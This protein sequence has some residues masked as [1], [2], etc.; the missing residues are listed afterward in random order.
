VPDI[1]WFRRDLRLTDHGG[2]DAAV[3]HEVVPVFVV[4]PRLWRSAGPVR[5]SRL[6]ASLRALDAGIRERGGAG[7]VV[8]RGPP[9][10]VVPDAA[11]E[12]GA[13]RV[14]HA[15][16]HTP[17]GRTRDA[18]VRVRLRQRG[19][20][21]VAADSPYL[22]PPGEVR[23]AAGGPYSVFT[24]YYRAWS[25][26]P[27]PPPF[28]GTEVQFAAAPGDGLPQL[29]RDVP[30][31]EPVARASLAAFARLRLDRYDVDRNRPDRD[32][33]SQL[34]AALHFGELHP[35]SVVAA[36]GGPSGAGAGFVRQMCW[37][38]FYADVMHRQPEAATDNIDRR[39]DR[40]PWLVGDEADRLFQAWA[41]G[42]TG[43]PFVDA[44]MRQLAQS[45]WMHNRVRM[46]VASF[47]TKD[48]LIHWNRGAAWFL[49]HLLD[50]DVANNALGWQWTAGTGTDAAPY[51]RVFNP[52]LQG[53]KFDSD[54]DYVRRFVPELAHLPGASVHEPWRHPGGYEHGYP[55]RIVDHAEA[56][57]QALGIYEQI[58]APSR[59][60][61][62]H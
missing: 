39:F 56:R 59:Q 5:R 34:G 55:E 10:E 19:I 29:E 61:E 40:M 24:P 30:G 2:L 58:K 23:T 14:L 54:G 45:G 20:A 28:P 51:F 12:L 32:A 13:E 21:L 9:A 25:A 22:H 3:G 47:L 62:P 37:R 35:R 42:R 43:Y 49:R 52:V 60:W 38:D 16:E 7:L 6:V 48:L 15:S 18:A 44:G 46:V 11:A 36:V 4:D 57:A 33:T 1:V 41:Q 53:L 31:G 17:Y 27:L 50:A 8:R 26:L